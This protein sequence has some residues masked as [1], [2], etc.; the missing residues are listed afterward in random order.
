ML[1][2]LC[3]RFIQDLSTGDVARCLPR[4]WEAGKHQGA[5]NAPEHRRKNSIPCRYRH[6]KTIEDVQDSGNSCEMCRYLSSFSKRSFSSDGKITKG[7]DLVTVGINNSGSSET[8][9]YDSTSSFLL[10]ELKRPCP[11]R[12]QIYCPV[13]GSPRISKYSTDV[14]RDP[15]AHGFFSAFSLALP[16]TA[17]KSDGDLDRL[18][19]LARVWLDNCNKNHQRCH[20]AKGLYLKEYSMLDLPTVPRIRTSVSLP[21]KTRTNHTLL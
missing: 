2:D 9:S 6:C 12:F 19:N 21:T 3:M 1:C 14:N 18:T 5:R 15:G 8:E 11:I 4:G 10:G 16:I 17:M 7:N 13:S 20:E